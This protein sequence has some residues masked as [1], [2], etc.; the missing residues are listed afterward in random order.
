MTYYASKNKKQINNLHV[1]LFVTLFLCTGIV[2][3]QGSVCADPVGGNGA[4]PFCST[5]GVVFPNCNLLN[6]SCVGSAEFGPNYG[7][8][9]TQPF[10][11]WYF[12]QIEDAGNLRFNIV[13]TQNEDGTGVPLDVDYICYGPFADPIAPCVSELNAGN[14]IDCSFSPSFNEFMTISN[15][16]VGEFYLVLITNYSGEAGF[17]SFQQVSGSG[18]TDCS[19]LEAVLGPNQNICGTDPIQIDG[20]TQ[21][22]VRYEWSVFNETTMVF[23]VIAGE[24]TP[25]LTVSVSGRYQLLVEDIDGDTETDEIVITF[26]E[27]PLVTSN[28]LRHVECAS[29]VLDQNTAIFNLTNNNPNVPLVASA[30]LRVVYYASKE[31]FDAKNAIPDSGISSFKNTSNPQTIFASVVDMNTDCESA[32]TARLDLLVESLPFLNNSETVMGE[33]EICVFRDGRV[34]TSTILGEDIGSID[35]QVYRYDWTPDNQDLDGDGNEDALFV[36]DRLLD[37]QVYTL[38]I[39]KVNS[40]GTG[41]DC[42]NRVDPVS[43]EVYQIML[44]P[45]ASPAK[46]DYEVTESAFSKEFTITVI[47]ELSVGRLSDFEYRLDR[48]IGNGFLEYRSFQSSPVFSNVP[49]GDYLV[50]ARYANCPAGEEVL[51]DVIMILGYP[52]YF[53]PNG[54]GFHDTWSLINIEDQPT[55]QIYIYDRYGKLL[56]QLRAGGPGWDGTYNGKNMPSSDYWFR[57]EFNEPRDPNM[58]RR[59]FTG[60]FSLIR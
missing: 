48:D 54:D 21:E 7:C 42:T 57:V 13:Q 9:T 32:F 24:T 3:A 6:S 38:S 60:N 50:T 12:L 47:P 22:A 59:V 43:G 30:N 46:L 27:L 45:V 56:K 19:I 23:D 41:L 36:I 53:T 40:S 29:S 8:L 28:A 5:T 2:S 39:T 11:A 51:S 33:K 35:G 44:R 16:Q 34:Q 14:I 20:T 58:S 31:D 17:I 4:D 26:N 15:A 52:K 18:A 55:A 37:D 10:P 1:I 49:P 25:L